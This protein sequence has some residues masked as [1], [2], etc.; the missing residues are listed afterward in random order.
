MQGII[1]E[2]I[3]LDE[4][5]RHAFDNLIH[6]QEKIKSNFDKKAIDEDFRRVILFSY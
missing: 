2:L 1:N 4:N 3:E 6:N 5:R